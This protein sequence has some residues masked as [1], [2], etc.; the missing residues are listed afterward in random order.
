MSQISLS[1][2]QTVTHTHTHAHT[3]THH[4]SI[5]SEY[6]Y[7]KSYFSPICIC[8]TRTLSHSHTQIHST[9]T[10]TSFPLVYSYCTELVGFSNRTR[11]HTCW[12]YPYLCHIATHI[13][14]L[15]YCLFHR[16]G[17]AR[18]G[19]EQRRNYDDGSGVGRIARH[20]I[21]APSAFVKKSFCSKRSF[22]SKLR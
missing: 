15:N 4:T 22:C 8:N 9:N 11:T 3:K 6:S 16:R 1:L 17:P 14:S 7:C 2:I 10:D 20:G 18:P 21:N 12:N 19:L 5:F 13:Q